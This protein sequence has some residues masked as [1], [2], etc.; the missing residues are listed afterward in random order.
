MV[1]GWSLAINAD[2]YGN[3]I[4]SYPEGKGI[5]WICWVYDPEWGPQ[6][7]KSWDTCELTESGEFFEKSMHGEEKV[8]TIKLKDADAR[9][10]KPS[11]EISGFNL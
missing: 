11:V 8:I 1:P 3:K 9:G 6:L 5:S 10:E 7:L 4:I 2:H